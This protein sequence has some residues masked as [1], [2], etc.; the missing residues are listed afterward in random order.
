[1]HSHKYPTKKVYQPARIP[2]YANKDAWI[3]GEPSGMAAGLTAEQYATLATAIERELPFPV[4]LT[5]NEQLYA[6]G[7]VNI[8]PTKQDKPHGSSYPRW[9]EEQY[10]AVYDF[11]QRHG[12]IITLSHLLTPETHYVHASGI[13]YIYQTPAD[14]IE[15]A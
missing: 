4:R 13:W 7:T 2:K 12:L 1:M 9:T 15:V 8:L 5:V 3:K 10:Q 11:M 14:A 6:F